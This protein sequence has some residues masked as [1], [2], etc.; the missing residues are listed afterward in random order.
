MYALWLWVSVTLYFSFPS[1]Q[2]KAFSS[3]PLPSAQHTLR[4]QRLSTPR[5]ILSLQSVP[6]DHSSTA[7][8]S[9]IDP[10][11][12]LSD[13][14]KAALFQ[15]LLRDLEVEGVPL[16][17]VDATETHVFQAALWTTMAELSENDDEGKVCVIFESIPVGILRQFVDSFSALKTHHNDEDNN[18]ADHL[19]ELQRFSV[20]LV[21]K[22][23]GPALIVQTEARTDEQKTAYSAMKQSSPTPDEIRWT[24]A[25]KMFVARM[26]RGI[27]VAHHSS[28]DP[29][30]DNSQTSI[31]YRVVG[32]PDICDVVAGFWTS[33]CELLSVSESQ[34]SSIVLSYPPPLQ[35]DETERRDRFS[36]A[37]DLITRMLFL[38]NG[39]KEFELVHLQ[40]FYDRDSVSPR[41]K[42]VHGH[43][44]PLELVRAMAKTAGLADDLDSLSDEQLALQNFQ[45]RSPLPGVIIERASVSYFSVSTV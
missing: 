4:P 29:S 5:V 20:S 6:P 25:M 2:V 9:S 42:P 19:P 26:V 23:I 18:I 16:L 22:G 36:A 40:P 11:D 15:F 45:R 21:G 14:R 41:D 24:A 27:N 3:F 30:A 32:S 44:P 7:S 35:G 31:A 37:A 38:Y 43:L 10:V 39:D 34:I 1:F 17:G 12:E 28:D 13:E 33:I 8:S